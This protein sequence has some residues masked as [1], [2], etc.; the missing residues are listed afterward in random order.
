[1]VGSSEYSVILVSIVINNYNYGRFLGEAIESGLAQ[2]VAAKEVIV[3]DDGSTD[4]S[5]EVMASFGD[6]IVPLY[7]ANGGQASAFNVGFEAAKGKWILF[8]DADDVLDPKAASSAIEAAKSSNDSPVAVQF[9]LQMVNEVRVRVEPPR[10]M[11]LFLFNGDP[12]P[13]M[14]K[15]G[16]Y[17]FSP[18]SGNLFLREALASVLPMPEKQFRLCADVY[19]QT[20][21]PF[22]GP[23][24]F[25]DQILGDYRVHTKNNHF[26]KEAKTLKDLTRSAYYRR[27]KLDLIRKLAATH[28][29][30]LSPYFEVHDC[31]QVLKE[32]ICRRLN[33]GDDYPFP[34]RRKGDD[35]RQLLKFTFSGLGKTSSLSKLGILAK[36]MVAMWG[37][38]VLVRRLVDIDQNLDENRN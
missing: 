17:K 35:F 3:V 9:L 34:P 16:K 32:W 37:P 10:T 12:V 14:L 5:R 18:T 24:L 4:H 21:L 27:Q 22:I 2:T 31:S 6:Q 25:F 19:L 13:E 38:Q 11:P 7:K 28:K 20:S 26:A 15:S 29:K 8:L 36:T 1:M 23:I 30:P 33:Q